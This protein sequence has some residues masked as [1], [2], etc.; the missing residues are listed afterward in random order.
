MLLVW[1]VSF[2]DDSYRVP[3]IFLAGAYL[4]HTTGELCLSPVGLSAITKLSPAA[5]VSFMMAGWFLSSSF[6]QY[7][8][9][10]IATFTATDTV[11]G[12][13]LDPEAALNGYASVFQAIGLVAIV[14][15]IVVGVFSFLLKKLG[16]GRAED[17]VMI[18]AAAEA[19]GPEQDAHPKA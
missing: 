14:L 16:H 11:A 6:A 1:G 8:A 18:P 10:I 9:G 19:A 3:L 12:Q 2:A 13:V 15:G 7:V 4:L 17:Q 5:V